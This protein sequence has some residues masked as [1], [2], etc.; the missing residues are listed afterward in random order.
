MEPVMTSPEIC[1]AP[2]DGASEFALL[3]TLFDAESE[4]ERDGGAEEVEIGRRLRPNVAHVGD[5]GGIG[6]R[7]PPRR[8]TRREKRGLPLDVA[9]V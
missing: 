2:L 6:R 7:S 1:A 4:V 9:Y 8:A 5:I 3:R